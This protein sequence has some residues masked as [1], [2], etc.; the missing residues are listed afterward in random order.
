MSGDAAKLLRTITWRTERSSVMPVHIGDWMMETQSMTQRLKH[1]CTQL[2]V[3]LC[4]EGFITPQALGEEG[5]QLP[6][7]E[8]YWLREVVLYGDGRPWLFGRSIVPQRTL[9]ATDSALM[10]IG[11]EPLGRYLFAQESLTRDYIHIGCGEGV[12]ARRSRLCLSGYPLLL[13]EL[14]LPESPVYINQ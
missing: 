6:P 3:V 7:D 11:A 4:H 9:N 13:T 5:E 14:F 1:Y 2:K 8:R 10:K 12:W